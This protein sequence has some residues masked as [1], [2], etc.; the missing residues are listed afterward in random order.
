MQQELKISNNTAKLHQ[1]FGKKLYADKYS[2][3]SELC[4]NAVD[5]HRMAGEK[6]P[7]VVGI[8]NG[9][10]FVKD[11]GLS[12]K[13]K[14]DFI[15]KVCTLLESGKSDKKDNSE[16]CAMGEHGIGSISVSAYRSDWIY[17]VVTP[18]GDHFKCILRE[19]EG[20]GL[21]YEIKDLGK[22]DEPK[23][24]LVQVEV[25]GFDSP[26]FVKKIK[27]KLCYFKDIMFDF[28]PDMIKTHPDLLVINTTFKLFQSDDFQV[29][30]LSSNGDMHISLDQYHYS[31]RWSL[32]GIDP[33]K[34]NIALKFSMADGLKADITRE[35][36][37]M[38]ENYKPL[39]LDK[40]KKVAIW[41]VSK[42]NQM[43]QKELTSI[44]EMHT[45][46]SAPKT[47][48]I[49]N[50]KYDIHQLTRHTSVVPNT[51][52]FKNVSL[53]VFT[54]FCAH[55]RNGYNLYTLK[56]YITSKG[57]FKDSYGGVG[58]YLSENNYGSNT[59]LV[60]GYFT[61]EKTRYMRQAMK[62]SK[63]YIR[64]KLS[65]GK[66]GLTYMTILGKLMGEVDVRKV[67]AARRKDVLKDYVCQI[68]EL[69]KSTENNYFTHK[70]SEIK[71]PPREKV[72]RKAANRRGKGEIT[73]GYPRAAKR[74]NEYDA[75][76]ESKIVKVEEL[77]RLPHFIVYGTENDKHKLSNYL[78]RIAITTKSK[79]IPCMIS[80]KCQEKIKDLELH[81]FMKIDEFLA[82]KHRYFRQMMTGYFILTEL[83]D[84]YERIFKNMQIIKDYLSPQLAEEMTKLKD[85]RSKFNVS[86]LKGLDSSFVKELVDLTN[87]GKLYDLEIWGMYERIKEEI[88]NFDFVD[89]FANSIN[90][91]PT[92][93]D[94]D[95][96]VRA[97][98]DIAKYR[99]I[100][101]EWKNYK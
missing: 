80:E 91:L 43:N 52:S 7:V 30:T 22:T 15:S 29:S 99:K 89:F 83:E 19:I 92:P 16:N 46:L 72:T 63:F 61:P 57:V 31:I 2:F 20:K 1:M 41:F 79:L 36:L 58:A 45:A 18:I 88:P 55:T 81:N 42:Y 90:G 26:N 64:K 53:D 10:F 66:I 71:V 39:I 51:P 4:Q 95:R 96:A 62:D 40:I 78:F 73:I 21:M 35:N 86:Y 93:K 56:S 97:M 50:L 13:D 6:D 84:K 54:A 9:F 74:S 17:T 67:L 87:D 47:I 25:N 68:N 59:V 49:N 82:G 3:I 5:S 76:F 24:V 100:K 34:L 11:I 38:D 65:F 8:K 94:K 37:Y 12:F 23:S 44:R 70:L 33:I 69:I 60:D 85:Y 77:H 75:V 32:L 48:V 98:Q 28:G 101:M 27:E 14:D